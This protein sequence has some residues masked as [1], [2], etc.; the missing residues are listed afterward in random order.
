MPVIGYGAQLSWR[1]RLRVALA[2]RLAW[3]VTAASQYL[4]RSAKAHGANTLE[5]PLGVH[6]DWFQQPMQRPVGPPWRLLHVASLNRVKDQTTLLRAMRRVVDAE[7]ETRLDV[8]GEDTLRG[9]IQ[10]LCESLGLAEKVFFHG[11][12]P[13]DETRPFFH[14][15]HLFL[16][17]SRHDAAPVAMLEAAATGLPSVGTQTNGY[18]ADWHPHAALAV[19]PGNEQALAEAILSLLHDPERRITMGQNA[20]RWAQAHDSHWTVQEF[21]RL[22][23]SISTG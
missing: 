18:A 19:P 8:I 2:L 3:Q 7:P 6:P 9:E 21:D 1:G 17:P 14:Q 22:Y 16:L 23:H 12:L 10:R 4:V 11:F 5:I 15:A 20:Q 13:N